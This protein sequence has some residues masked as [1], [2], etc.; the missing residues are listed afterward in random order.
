MLILSSQ[1]VSHCVKYTFSENDLPIFTL[2]HTIALEFVQWQ[3]T[4]IC[5]LVQLGIGQQE[6]LYC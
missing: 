2:F 4:Y 3:E 6:S 1:M 5:H